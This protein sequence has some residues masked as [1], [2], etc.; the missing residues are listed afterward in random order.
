MFN[1]KET[2]QKNL[3]YSFCTGSYHAGKHGEAYQ[4]LSPAV[5]GYCYVAQPTQ[6]SAPGLM[7]TVMGAINL[8]L[9]PC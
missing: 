8:A 1:N 9:T 6:V 7:I 2:D 3:L 4:T 5:P